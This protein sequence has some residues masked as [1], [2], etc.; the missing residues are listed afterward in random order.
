M[1]KKRLKNFPEIVRQEIPAEVELSS[2]DV[3][4]QDEARFGQRNTVNRIWAEKGSRPGLIRQQQCQNAYI[5]GA[6]CPDRDT[7]VALIMPNADANALKL[8][9]DEIHKATSEGRHAVVLMDIS[10]FKI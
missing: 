2:V 4:A 5:F 7:G 8:H 3:W 6:V 10:G 9:L 1:S